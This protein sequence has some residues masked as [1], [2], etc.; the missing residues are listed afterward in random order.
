MGYR[1]AKDGQNSAMP[2][3]SLFKIVSA[4][5]SAPRAAS[6]NSIPSSFTPHYLKT[7]IFLIFPLAYLTFRSSQS[8]ALMASFVSPA[9]QQSSER[10]FSEAVCP[11]TKKVMSEPVIASDGFTY[12][13]KA[14]EA[15]FEDGHILSPRTNTPLVSKFLFL[16]KRMADSIERS[17]LKR[18][19]EGDKESGLV[20]PLVAFNDIK[21]AATRKSE[22]ELKALA[23]KADLMRDSGFSSTAIKNLRLAVPHTPGTH[24][25]SRPRLKMESLSTHVSNTVVSVDEK[26]NQRVL[27]ELTSSGRHLVTTY[28]NNALPCLLIG[29]TQSSR[30]S[31]LSSSGAFVGFEVTSESQLCSPVLLPSKVLSLSSP[32]D[33]PDYLVSVGQEKGVVRIWRFMES[34]DD[35]PDSTRLPSLQPQE[36]K[37]KKKK[38]K[39]SFMSMITGSKKNDSNYSLPSSGRG[40]ASSSSIFA[41]LGRWVISSTVELSSD[42]LN[43]CCTTRNGNTIFVGDRKGKLSILRNKRD[44][45]TGT[46]WKVKAEISTNSYNREISCIEIEKEG[47][48]WCAAAVQSEVKLY[49]IERSGFITKPVT[50]IESA[51]RLGITALGASLDGNL[52]VS[53]GKKGM[54][55]G[56]DARQKQGKPLFSHGNAEEDAVVGVCIADNLNLVFVADEMGRAYL[57]DTRTWEVLETLS[58]ADPKMAV[59]TTVTTCG[60]ASN[61]HE[62]GTSFSTASSDGVVRTW[63]QEYEGSGWQYSQVD[64]DSVKATCLASS[65][66]SV[67]REKNASNA[68]AYD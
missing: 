60:A 41:Y 15:Y 8:F 29:G 48:S 11:L 36:S 64:L 1:C 59:S 32:L 31:S 54:V 46:D 50:T 33:F 17:G 26:T 28:L 7:L 52:L 58:A 19:N 51:H 39:K 57:L 42:W 34:E 38:K 16:N 68:S 40:F 14:I 3:I 2:G 61:D 6:S 30:G 62:S 63:T 49:D 35:N 24:H 25:T 66:M 13:R 18:M 47:G 44:D 21:A 23:S 56:W 20:V 37:K 55:F 67:T 10:D 5:F 9:G 43:S 12:E 65:S 22:D 4:F 27:S 45:P 53:G